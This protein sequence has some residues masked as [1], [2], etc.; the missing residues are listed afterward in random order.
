MPLFTSHLGF[1]LLFFVLPTPFPGTNFYQ[2]P[3]SV[4][5]WPALRLEK[6]SVKVWESKFYSAKYKDYEKKYSEQNS[7]FFPED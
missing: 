6:T 3:I 4:A 2:F 7:D 5:V 1:I